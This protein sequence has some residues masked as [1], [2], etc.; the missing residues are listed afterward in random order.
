MKQTCIAR[1]S[2][3]TYWSQILAFL[4]ISQHSKMIAR[5]LQWAKK[6]NNNGWI[7][8]LR[9]KRLKMRSMNKLICRQDSWIVPCFLNICWTPQMWP[10]WRRET[11]P[12]YRAQ[13]IE[14]DR[15]VLIIQGTI[16]EV[17]LQEIILI[18]QILLTQ[19]LQQWCQRLSNQCLVRA[20]MLHW[21]KLLLLIRPEVW[22]ECILLIG[23]QRQLWHLRN[24]ELHLYNEQLEVESPWLQQLCTN[25]VILFHRLQCLQIISRVMHSSTC[26]RNNSSTTTSKEWRTLE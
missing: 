14:D 26:A 13:Q 21:L 6:D 1:E 18:N 5:S 4:K 20:Q 19:E 23:C 17:Q 11:R 2:T 3:S 8:T 15:V 10:R 9:N 7:T 22:V 24:Q 12:R 25:Q 16:V